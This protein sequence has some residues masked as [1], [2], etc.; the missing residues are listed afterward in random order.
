[1]LTLTEDA[2]GLG[3]FRHKAA[4][5]AVKEGAAAG[6]GSSIQLHY[7]RSFMIPKT[8][9]TFL[10]WIQPLVH[11]RS[12]LW[13][14]GSQPLPPGTEIWMLAIPYQSSTQREG[15]EAGR[16]QTDAKYVAPKQLRF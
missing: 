13:A 14:V 8:S 5:R 12:S 9:Q 2:E 16:P 15:W 3:K 6:I 10:G 7:T 11:A 4:G 1:M